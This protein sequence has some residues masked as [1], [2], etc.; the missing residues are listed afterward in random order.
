VS[1]LSGVLLVFAAV[2]P[3]VSGPRD[4]GPERDLCRE[5]NGLPRGEAL[6][7]APGEYLGDAPL[8]E[9]ALTYSCPLRQ[10]LAVYGKYANPQEEGPR[11]RGQRRRSS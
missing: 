2:W 10:S 8:G 4:I 11:S 9:L 6:V 7:L 5:I 3:S 1:L